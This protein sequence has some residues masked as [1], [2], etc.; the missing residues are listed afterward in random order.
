MPLTVHSTV[1]P[2]APPPLCALMW[3]LTLPVSG[4]YSSL[5]HGRATAFAVTG[6]LASHDPFLPVTKLQPVASVLVT[7]SLFPGPTLPSA[8]PAHS[9]DVPAS[10]SVSVSLPFS[11]AFPTPTD[12]D[13]LVV[14]VVVAAPLS[15]RS[16]AADADAAATALTANTATKASPGTLGRCMTGHS[17][18]VW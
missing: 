11:V 17:L 6:S 3:S 15:F 7:S 5:T 18:A 12:S 8:F 14:A 16:G 13:Q 1:Q 4:S 10:M 2:G 9:I